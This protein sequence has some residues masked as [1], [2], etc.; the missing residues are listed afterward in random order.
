MLK[1]MKERTQASRPSTAAKTTRRGERQLCASIPSSLAAIDPLC[2][3]LRALLARYHLESMQFPVEIVARECLNNA[4]LHGNR[5][6]AHC[7]V[8]FDIRVGRKLI[9]LRVSD[10][11][12]GFNWRRNRRCHCPGA[13]AIKGR[14]L[15]IFKVYADRIAFNRRG[16]QVTVWIQY[17]QAQ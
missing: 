4:I 9:R 6:R 3:Q 16:N 7:K 1:K 17:R 8:T 11:G 10:R 14:G 12:S 2:E 5:R 15:P 13:Q